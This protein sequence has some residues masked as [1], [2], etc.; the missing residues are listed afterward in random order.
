MANHHA[1]SISAIAR[2]SAIAAAAISTAALLMTACSDSPTS[3]SGTGSNL[4]LMLTDA[5]AGVDQVNVYFTTVTFFEGK[6]GK[7]SL[8]MP[9]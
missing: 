3:P 7:Y 4:R 2:R 6:P 8:K 5:P 1:F 9:L